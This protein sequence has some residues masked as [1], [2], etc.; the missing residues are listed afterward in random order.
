MKHLTPQQQLW[1]CVADEEKC[2]LL[3]DGLKHLRAD[4]QETLCLSLL[5]ALRW[6]MKP[7]LGNWWMQH[8]A[9]MLL[10]AIGHSMKKT[11]VQPSK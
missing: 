9:Y 2:K 4:S 5:A 3:A 10:E 11:D 6:G 1:N 8:Q 7:T